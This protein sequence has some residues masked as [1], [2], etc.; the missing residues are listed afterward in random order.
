VWAA[1][2][3]LWNVAGR[4]LIEVRVGSVR[5]SRQVLGW[6]RAR[7]Y[8]AEHIQ[9]LRVSPQT[10]SSWLGWQHSGSPFA[11]S[12][13][14]AFDYGARTIRFG[15]A[16]EAEARQILAEIGQR[17]PQYRPRATAG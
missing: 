7:D 1:Y 9:D 10:R 2:V 6:G 5:L 12:G 14:L 4:E 17:F 15:D 11:L 8:V 16:D 13:Q 3:W